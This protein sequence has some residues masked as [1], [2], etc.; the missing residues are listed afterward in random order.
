MLSNITF[1]T[2]ETVHMLSSVTYVTEEHFSSIKVYL[3]MGIL[4]S[5]AAVGV[6]E[7]V[8]TVIDNSP[9]VGFG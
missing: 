1:V 9:G 3:A 7:G 5:G 2:E 4:G 6:G 8:G